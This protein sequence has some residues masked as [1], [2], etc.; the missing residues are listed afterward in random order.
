MHEEASRWYN[1]NMTEVR[2]VMSFRLS[3]IRKTK[4]A[5]F[6]SKRNLFGQSGSQNLQVFMTFERMNQS[7]YSQNW[8]LDRARLDSFFLKTGR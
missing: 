5:Q 2:Q 1:C 6:W 3:E 8:L 7:V 4:G